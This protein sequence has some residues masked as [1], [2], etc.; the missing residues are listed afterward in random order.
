[1]AKPRKCHHTLQS[2]HRA[3]GSVYQGSSD[4]AGAA[5]LAH[6]SSCGKAGGTMRLGSR[7][8]NSLA[9]LVWM[10]SEQRS[11]TTQKDYNLSQ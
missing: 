5:L 8:S 2:Q 3:H 4:Q 6:S 9:G 1:M 7:L 11:Q 10:K